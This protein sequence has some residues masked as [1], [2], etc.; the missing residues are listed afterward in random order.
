MTARGT[1][2]PRSDHRP[3]PVDLT[4]TRTIRPAPSNSTKHFHPSPPGTYFNT[5]WGLR[6]FKPNTTAKNPCL[7]I[8][9]P[10]GLNTSYP[11]IRPL[12]HLPG[13]SNIYRHNLFP[14]LNFQ[15][16]Q[17]NQ[18]QHTRNILSQ[19]PHIDLSYSPP[20]TIARRAPPTIRVY[21]KM[22][23]PTRTD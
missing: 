15:T 14:L 5:R 16:K 12:P 20:L 10:P 8:N 13:P 7:L 21:A 23:H 4:K 11:T 19:I 2:G 3:N 6:R 18:Y 9:C 17:S 22:T 1:S